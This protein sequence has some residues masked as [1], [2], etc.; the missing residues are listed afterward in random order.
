M[1]CWAT[2]D[3]GACSQTVGF[4][5]AHEQPRDEEHQRHEEVVVETDEQ[6]EPF[7]MRV[8]IED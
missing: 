2:I 4:R 1:T 3:G 6:G 7:P 8:P 5:L